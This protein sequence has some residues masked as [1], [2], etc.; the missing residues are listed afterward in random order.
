MEFQYSILVDQSIEKVWEFFQTPKS[1]MLWQP[2]ILEETI[3]QNSPA[4]QMGSTCREIRKYLGWHY[5][6]TWE[7]TEFI[8][9]RKIAYRS[10][11]SP[12]VYEGAYL[13][14]RIGEGTKFTYWLKSGEGLILLKLMG[15]IS[16]AIYRKQLQSDLSRLKGILEAQVHAEETETPTVIA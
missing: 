12:I 11:V 13:F 9:Q 14:E 6:S 3:V 10:I 8:P 5:E 7:I 4:Y 16:K 15:P 1:E 2:S